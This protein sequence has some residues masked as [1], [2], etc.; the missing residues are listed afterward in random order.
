MKVKE[1]IKEL[2]VLNPEKNVYA[3]VNWVGIKHV[4]FA[5][6]EVDISTGKIRLIIETS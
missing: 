5:P 6:T 1:L 2:E 4:V 3:S